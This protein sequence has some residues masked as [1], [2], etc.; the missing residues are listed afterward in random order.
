MTADLFVSLFYKEIFYHLGPRA[1]SLLA[2]ENGA[3]RVTFKYKR[4]ATPASLT[5]ALPYEDSLVLYLMERN[6][7][8]KEAI[9]AESYRVDYPGRKPAS[10]MSHFTVKIESEL[11][12]VLITF[13]PCAFSHFRH[14]Y[15]R[16]PV[17]SWL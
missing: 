1:A 14:F 5:V 6:R 15:F 7:A 8:F 10:A 3:E 13:Y 17:R 9:Y 12:D 16:I 2:E 4:N 11:A